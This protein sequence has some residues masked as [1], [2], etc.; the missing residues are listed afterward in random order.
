MH[1]RVWRWKWFSCQSSYVLQ[2]L[3]LCRASDTVFRREI[4]SRRQWGYG[5]CYGDSF[6][7]VK[8]CSIII[9]YS[10]ILLCVFL[11]GMVVNGFVNVVISTI[12]KRYELA[13]TQSGTIASAYDIASVICLIPVSYLGGVGRKPRWLGSGIFLM[14]VGSFVFALP[15]FLSGLYGYENNDNEFNS[16]QLGSATGIVGLYYSNQ[17]IQ[18]CSGI[19]W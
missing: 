11:Q 7:A 16:C 13:S 18:I 2:R 15:H 4:D 9:E 3:R 14:G 12:E 17:I 19:T 1:Q 5:T 8:K 10:F 6:P